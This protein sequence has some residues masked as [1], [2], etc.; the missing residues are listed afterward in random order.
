[1]KHHFVKTENYRQ[2]N[3]AVS[4]MEK[5][6]SLSSPLCLLHGDPGVGKT[7]NISNYGAQNSAVLFKGHVGQNLDGLIWAIGQQLGVKHKTNRTAAMT[8]QIAALR[9]LGA[10]IIYDEAQFGLSMRWQKIKWAG[11]EYLRQLGESACTFVI[12]VCHNS[13][14]IK[15]SESA[16]ISTRIA[17]RAELYNASEKDT[18][19]FVHELSEVEVGEGVGEFVHKQTRGKYRLIENAISSLER[20]AKVKGICRIELADLGNVTLVVDHEQGLVPRIA[21]SA[22]NAL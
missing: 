10:P 9:E 15:F 19:A 11:I 13:E 6:G 1:M 7:C 4:F 18:V 20:I 16:H 2:L 22:K 17:H 8:D 3:A 12:L 21:K 14:V 5:R